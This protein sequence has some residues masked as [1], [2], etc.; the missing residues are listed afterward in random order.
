MRL[1]DLDGMLR[2]LFLWATLTPRRACA[3]T[4][5]RVSQVGIASDRFNI[6]DEGVEVSLLQHTDLSNSVHVSQL[7]NVGMNG[8]VWTLSDAGGCRYVAK[9]RPAGQ[10]GVEEASQIAALYKRHPSL[11]QQEYVVVP[12]VILNIQSPSFRYLGSLLVAPE[13]PGESLSELLFRAITPGA[14]LENNSRSLLVKAGS[15]IGE[16]LCKL[17]KRYGKQH[18][19]LHSSN[20]IVDVTGKIRFID[21]A[22]LGGSSH[23]DMRYLKDSLESLEAAYIR[24]TDQLWRVLQATIDSAY[25][26]C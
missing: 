13:A 23:S 16:S 9:W 3:F 8:G 7:P 15:S 25:N 19:D 26:R 21:I 1:F 11:W 22:T 6:G 12:Q 20:I 10:H 4:G 5:L 2:N 14:V 24:P 18:G 17:H